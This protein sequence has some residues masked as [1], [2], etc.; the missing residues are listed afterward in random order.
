MENF[1]AMKMFLSMGE[2]TNGQSS[3]E[4]K[5]KQEERIIFATMRASIPDWQPP[6]DWQQLPAEEREKRI[7]AL[8]KL[9]L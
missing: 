9:D 8:K 1:K 4:E 6:T 7:N 3:K 5:L 2:L